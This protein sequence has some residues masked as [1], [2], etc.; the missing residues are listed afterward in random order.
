VTALPYRQYG[1][2]GI[3]DSALGFGIGHFALVKPWVTRYPT[4]LL[5]WALWKDVV[6]EPH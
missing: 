3:Q 2:P 1:S 4:S 6:L 5:K